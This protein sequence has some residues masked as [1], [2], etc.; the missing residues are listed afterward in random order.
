MI[1]IDLNLRPM[2]RRLGQPLTRCLDLALPRSCIGCSLS[3]QAPQQAMCGACTLALPGLEVPRCPRCAISIEHLRAV[4]PLPPCEL[5]ARQ[6]S[7]F[8][9]S[10]AL[11]NY[12]FP[13]DEMVRSLKFRRRWSLGEALGFSLG[14]HRGSAILA[15][16]LQIARELAAAREQH[17]NGSGTIR[18]TL[19]LCAIPLSAQRLIERG[20]NQS[21]LILNGLYLSLEQNPLA[22]NLLIAKANILIRRR[23]TEA[24]TL[25]E[26][27]TRE[28]N[29][30]EAFETH[31]SCTNQIVVL[32]DDV[33]T[34]GATLKSAALTLKSAGAFAV[35]NAVLA[36]TA[37]DPSA[38]PPTGSR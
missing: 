8:D 2:L 37:Q 18:P 16:A 12:A 35:I 26:P 22:R 11:C 7:T 14:Q 5:C 9:A 30:L 23:N 15:Y 38:I 6:S 32:V 17:P 28:L 10:F 31:R 21:Q 1:A 19:N 24:Q 34:T 29:L 3:L 20:F 27:R 33:M 36:R 4:D 13:I 25:L